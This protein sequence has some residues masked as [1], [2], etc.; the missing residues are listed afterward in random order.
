MTKQ[1]QY[2]KICALYEHNSFQCGLFSQRC[3]YH[4][5]FNWYDKQVVTEHTDR[6][7]M[8]EV[9]KLEKEFELISPEN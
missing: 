4:R 5:E 3:K 8:E 1:C 9:R 2:Y 6:I 7:R